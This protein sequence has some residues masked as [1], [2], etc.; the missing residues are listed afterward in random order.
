[1]ADLHE[2]THKHWTGPEKWQVW[3]GLLGL[4]AAVIGCVSGFV[5]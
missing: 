5:R 4:I 3:I 2:K 1:M